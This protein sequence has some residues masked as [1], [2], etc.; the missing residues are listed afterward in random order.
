M[1]TLLHADEH[2]LHSGL[3]HFLEEHLGRFGAFVDEVLLHGILDTLKLVGF[4]FLT[5]LLMEFIEHRASDKVRH[6]MKKAGVCGPLV[7]GTMGAVPQCGFSAVASNLYTGRVVTLG[8]LVAVFLSTSDEMIP[9]LASSG[10]SAVAILLI[11][12]YKI[13]VGVAV[14]FAVD[15]VL[16]LI[17]KSKREI[18]ID[19][20]CEADDCHCEK[21]ILRSALHHTLTVSLFVLICTIAIGALYFFVGEENLSRIMVDIPF[22]SHLICSVIGLVPNCAASVVLAKFAV[23]GFI[24]TGAMISGLLTGAGAGILVLF[25]MNKSLRDNLVI[26]GILVGAG[27]VFGMIA[28]LIPFL[29]V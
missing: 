20:I 15:G 6:V 26:V 16:R 11:V 5:Y 12:V 1:N 9:V 10:V 25:R 27:V 24:S 17:G 22:V 2:G 19:Q 3:S 8:T 28:D 14:G 21:G 7:G 13:L 23:S 29:S 4:L 18:D